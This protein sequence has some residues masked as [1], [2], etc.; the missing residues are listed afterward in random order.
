MN[1]LNL[2][3]QGK[4]NLL[5]DLYRI[6]KGFRRKLSLF[7]SQLE[8]KSISY[9]VYFKEYSDASTEEINLDFFYPYGS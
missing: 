9:V 8:G 2:K 7:E 3:L 5:C 4:D 1:E 6:T